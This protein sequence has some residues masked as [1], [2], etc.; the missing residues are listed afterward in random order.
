MGIGNI[1]KHGTG[2]PVATR[3]PKGN[4]DDGLGAFSRQRP[5]GR[6]LVGRD[7]EG[8]PVLQ[9]PPKRGSAEELRANTE[10][11]FQKGGFGKIKDARRRR[12]AAQDISRGAAIDQLAGQ[13]Q[14]RAG[15]ERRLAQAGRTR[16]GAFTERGLDARNRQAELAD[17]LQA[18]A[19]GQAGPSVAEQQLQMGQDQATQNAAALAA[20]SR[21][22]PLLAQR[23]AQVQAGQAQAQTNAEAA[24]LRAQEQLQAQQQLGQVAGQLRAQDFGQAQLGSQRDLAGRQLGSQEQQTAIENLLAQRQLTQNVIANKRQGNIA[25]R[26]QDM[27]LAGSV[28]GGG[29]GFLSGMAASDERVKEDVDEG[30]NATRELLDALSAKSYRYKEQDQ[31]RP[32]A[33][34]GERVGI[35]AQDLERSKVGKNLVHES[36]DG[37]KH[38]D[39]KGATSAALAALADLHQ[40]VGSLE[41]KGGDR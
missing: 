32:G 37:T 41:G 29:G 15:A 23:Q 10:L 31:G 27:T 34:P 35:L 26:Q 11:A 4:R 39:V 1:G 22:N 6:E 9:Q 17:L 19:T 21:G 38:Y 3:K 18:R 33:G 24:R 13:Q 25:R 7:E 40:R 20:Q 28:L 16:L 30:S 12:S 14:Q 8:N 36:E 2:S 5:T